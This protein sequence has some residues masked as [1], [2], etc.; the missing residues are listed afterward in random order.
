MN[1]VQNVETHLNLNY[2]GLQQGSPRN[3]PPYY[4]T[5]AE[6]CVFAHNMLQLMMA[7]VIVLR[8]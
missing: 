2:V 3:T 6:N 7:Y 1:T 8:R 5:L 4:N